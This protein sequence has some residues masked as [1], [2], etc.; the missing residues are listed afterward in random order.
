MPLVAV[1]GLRLRYRASGTGAPPAILVHGAGMCSAVWLGVQRRLARR[2]RTLALD[3]PGHGRS[4][5]A[6]RSIEEMSAAVMAFA[7]GLGLDRYAV[8]GHSL[9]GLV[10]LA[11]ALAAPTRVAALA[12]CATGARLASSAALIAAAAGDRLAAHLAEAAFAPETPVE[13]RRRALALALAATPEQAAA[14]LDALARFDARGA[15]GAVLAPTLVVAGEDDRLAPPALAAE[16]GAGIP[17]ARV[18]ILTRCAHFPMI[19][20]ADALVLALDS[21]LPGLTPRTR[22]PTAATNPGSA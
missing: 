5:G 13:T 20:Q 18:Q 2:R 1:A 6:P 15:L 8:V 21:F 19:E 16:L 14:D 12:L 7:D 4:S 10:A 11:A 3:L 17:G 9:G 22:Q